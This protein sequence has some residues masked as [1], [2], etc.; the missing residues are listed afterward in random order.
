MPNSPSPSIHKAEWRWTFFAKNCVWCSSWTANS[1]WPTPKP[2][3]EIAAKTPRF[4]N[5]GIWYCAFFATI[6]RDDWTTSSTQPCGHWRTKENFTEEH[7]N[8]VDKKGKSYGIVLLGIVA[9]GFSQGQPIARKSV[10]FRV[11]TLAPVR[12]AIT[13]IS[14]SIIPGFPLPSRLASPARVAAFT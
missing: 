14:P 7:L 9:K 13:A 10:M 8:D 5:M 4:R 6:W 12:M 11:A 1:T 2:T 3:G